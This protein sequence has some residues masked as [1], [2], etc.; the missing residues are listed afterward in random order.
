MAVLIVNG[1]VPLALA[2]DARSTNASNITKFCGTFPF[3]EG[4]CVSLIEESFL[5]DEFK[6]FGTVVDPNAFEAQPLGF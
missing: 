3:L 5:C 1:V 6:G 4:I 2:L